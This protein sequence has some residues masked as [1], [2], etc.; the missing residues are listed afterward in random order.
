MNREDFLRLYT[1]TRS[2]GSRFMSLL[3]MPMPVDPLKGNPQAQ[4]ERAALGPCY[5]TTT[6]AGDVDLDDIARR[7][8]IAARESEKLVSRSIRGI[9]QV[10]RGGH[11]VIVPKSMPGTQV[12][13][14]HSNK[15]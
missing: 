8:R 12:A 6:L 1:A 7:D 3:D 10:Q 11:V 2:K 13:G 4:A 9:T 15:Y 14:Y 5:A